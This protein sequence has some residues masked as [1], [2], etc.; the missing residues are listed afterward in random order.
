MADVGVLYGFRV[1]PEDDQKAEK[2]MREIFDAMAAEEFPTG[3]VKSYALFRDASTPGKWVLFEHF[4]DAGARKHGTG[5]L[6][7]GPGTRHQELLI[8]PYERI[9]LDPVIVHGCGEKISGTPEHGS[10]PDDK[11]ANVGVV[12]EY[13]V[14][15]ED[16]VKAEDV[17]REIFGVMAED[18]YPTGDVITYTLYRDPAELGHWYMFEYFTAAGSDN[19]ATGKKIYGPGMQ[20]QKMLIEPHKRALLDPVIVKGC[21]ESITNSSTTKQ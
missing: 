13:R 18:E 1:K 19:H 6:I 12:F 3:D 7:H 9:V 20:H 21:G 15:P 8:E 17:M 5:P 2:I 11:R 10:R 14:A 16:D 4:T